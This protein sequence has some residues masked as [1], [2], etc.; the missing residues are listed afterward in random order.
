MSNSE[1]PLSSLKLVRWL[2][3]QDRS[4][5][6]SYGNTVVHRC[7]K[8]LA[9]DSRQYNQSMDEPVFTATTTGEIDVRQTTDAFV[10]Q[11]KTEATV[12]RKFKRIA[13]RSCKWDIPRSFF[14][15]HVDVT[16]HALGNARKWILRSED[17]GADFYIVKYPDKNGL[18]ETFTELLI[19]QLGSACGFD[20]AHSGVASLDG[21]TVF[22]TRSFLAVD[23]HLV[24]GSFLIEDHFKAKGEL[25][26]IH[27]SKE[28][29]FYSVDFVVR[30]IEEYCGADGQTVI[31]KFVEM[32]L[33]DALVGTNDRHPQNWG[34]IRASKTPGG[35]RLAP[36]FDTARALLW[37]TSDAKLQELLKDE[38]LLRYH[39]ARAKPIIGPE[40][41]FLKTKSSPCNHFE[42]IGNLFSVL[43]HQMVTA[44]TKVPSNVDRI[45][46]RLLQRSFPFSG[47]PFSRLRRET[48]LKL[49]SIRADEL[50]RTLEKGGTTC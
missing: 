19:N 45:A 14:G 49:L 37:N 15:Y 8:N 42:F 23:E 11:I 4:I 48:I 34:V 18:I 1:H 12:P 5:S 3:R 31:E 39:I 47:K 7:R 17:G 33:F 38:K 36:I 24:H 21:E 30:T 16:Y 35:Y 10:K 26:N 22:V 50:S 41:K 9:T 44:V 20:M 27:R 6:K 46:A 13:A 25:D 2:L 28:Q 29:A 43:P 40:Q 32:L